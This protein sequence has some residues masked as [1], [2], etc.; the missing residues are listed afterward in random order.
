MQLQLRALRGKP[1]SQM[2]LKLPLVPLLPQLTRPWSTVENPAQAPILKSLVSQGRQAWG[3]RLH[4]PR[5]GAVFVYEYLNIPLQFLE[6]DK[7]ISCK[8]LIPQ[9]LPKLSFTLMFPLE[10]KVQGALAPRLPWFLL[11]PDVM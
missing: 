5:Q 10:V 1:P 7:A 3:H 9:N 11:L 8:Q 4:Y 6:T 2:T